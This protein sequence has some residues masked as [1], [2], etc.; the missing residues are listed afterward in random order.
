MITYKE[1]KLLKDKNSIYAC[2][3]KKKDIKDKNFTLRTP[4]LNIKNKDIIIK[5]T[6]KKYGNFDKGFL[7]FIKNLEVYTKIKFV[8]IYKAKYRYLKLFNKSKANIIFLRVIS[9]CLNES[10]FGDVIEI[11]NLRLCP[12]KINRNISYLVGVINGDGH[13]RKSETLLEITDGQSDKEKLKS[14][15]EYF[16]II[17][18]LIKKEFNVS[19]KKFK[20]ENEW[21]YN[22]NNKWLCR[23]INY[24]FKV[25]FGRKSEIIYFPNNLKKYESEFWRGIMDTDGFIDEKTKSIKIKSNSNKLIK[26]F[27]GFCSR[28]K[29]SFY[30]KEEKEAKAVNLFSESLYKYAEVIGFS[31]PRKKNILIQ[32]LKR[33][34]N[35]KVLISYNKDFDRDTI[36]L[37]KYLRPYKKNITY[38]KQGLYHQNG[39]KEETKKLIKNIEERFKIEATEVK[40]PRRSNHFYICS[41]KFR[42]FLIENVIYG[43]PWQPLNKQE[44]NNISRRWIL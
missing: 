30:T 23:Y 5:L 35:Y 16:E 14:S 37:L 11:N 28:N 27:E 13:L 43:L 26:Q 19:G 20:T 25:P 44:L 21:R 12:K 39:S 7:E 6:K 2:L 3:V 17:D 38:I 34:P 32:H 31:H 24:F 15:K 33:G 8:S 41:E 18:E 29:I 42:K 1:D 9:L 22:L 4:T 10:L 40:R 36:H